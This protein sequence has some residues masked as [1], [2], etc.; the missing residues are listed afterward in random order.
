VFFYLSFGES[1]DRELSA[2]FVNKRS[3]NWK[4]RRIMRQ[5]HM[6][7]SAFFL[8][9]LAVFFINVLAIPV[10]TTRGMAAAEGAGAAG[11]AA[12]G[13]TAAGLTTGTIAVGVTVAAVAALAIAT[14]GGSDTAV[15]AQ[16]ASS[17]AGASLAT[18]NPAAAS[19][20]AATLGT[21]NS[22]NLAA[23]STASTALGTTGQSTLASNASTMTSGQFATYLQTGGGY[24]AG[25]PQYNALTGIY[26]SYT[27]AQLQ[28]LQSM[29]A[30]AVSGG[31][32]NAATLAGISEVIADTTV[33][34]P[35]QQAQNLADAI[36]AILTAR[37]PGAAVI[38]TT[39]HHGNNVYTT[40]SHVR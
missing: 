6:K 32:V 16:S 20:T 22:T 7:G 2:V 38:V 10:L 27:P 8:F 14:G 31:T 9:V 34:T 28:A 35:A 11:A 3:F 25:S 17:Q 39:V 19:T 12:G 36:T 15:A 40:S 13:A 5:H 24:T 30:S 23:L 33:G 4:R 21:L 1:S 37:H 18:T 29:Y 26:S